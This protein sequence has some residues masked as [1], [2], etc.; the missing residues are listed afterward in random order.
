MPRSSDSNV[1][2]HVRPLS[3]NTFAVEKQIT[4]PETSPRW[5]R[6]APMRSH[7]HGSSA[8]RSDERSFRGASWIRSAAASGAN[9]FNPVGPSSFGIERTGSAG[10]RI[11]LH[12]NHDLYV[13]LSTQHL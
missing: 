7:G 11:G 3:I 6:P 4:K 12:Q 10:F 13:S 2:A 1:C 9:C 8:A 5:L